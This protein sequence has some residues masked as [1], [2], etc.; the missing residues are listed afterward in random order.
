MWPQ[1]KSWTEV[2]EINDHKP[3]DSVKLMSKHQRTFRRVSLLFSWHNY[4][5]AGLSHENATDVHSF[6]FAALGR[7]F[8]MHS[9]QMW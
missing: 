4:S 3:K 8:E 5:R 9:D 6:H 2:L 1:K 7:K